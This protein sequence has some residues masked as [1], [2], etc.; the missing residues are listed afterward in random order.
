MRAVRLGPMSRAMWRL[1]RRIYGRFGGRLGTLIGSWTVLLLTTTGR[2]SGER[3][4]VTLNFIDVDEGVAVIGSYAGED[5]D[6]AWVLNLRADPNATIQI[7]RDTTPVIGRE[8]LE[9]ERDRIA[10]MFEERD[11]SYTTY[12]ERTQRALPVFVF[13]PSE[14]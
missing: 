6:P 1:H 2:R 3:R 14:S 5:R 12:R 4:A 10:R 11:G 7:G 9:A 13:E 8:V